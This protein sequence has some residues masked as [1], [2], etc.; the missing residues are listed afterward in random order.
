M[1]SFISSSLIRDTLSSIT[2]KILFS[3][4][5]LV[6][7]V[8]K[9][10][11]RLFSFYIN[12]Q[13][14][15]F[16]ALRTTFSLTSIFPFTFFRINCPCS[17][18][19]LEWISKALLLFL[20]LYLTFYQA[21]LRIQDRILLV[22]VFWIQHCLIF[23]ICFHLLCCFGAILIFRLFLLFCRCWEN[24]DFFFLRIDI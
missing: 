3:P 15:H 22:L 6:L 1:L 2:L 18:Y 17:T 14:F 20:L 13:L 12:L 9:I 23:R 21:F 5:F 10:F 11:K 7:F 16:Q 4:S 8:I 24:L 19:R